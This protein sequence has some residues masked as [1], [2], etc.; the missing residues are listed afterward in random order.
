VFL[1]CEVYGRQAVVGN[2]R[3]AQVRTNEFGSNNVPMPST[4]EGLISTSFCI[5]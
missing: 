1:E 5:I 4:L 2:D 3:V